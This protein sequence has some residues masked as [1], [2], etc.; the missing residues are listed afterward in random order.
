MPHIVYQQPSYLLHMKPKSFIWD[1]FVVVETKPNGA[2]KTVQCKHDGCQY[3]KAA[4]P[5][6]MLQHWQADHVEPRESPDGPEEDAEE[7]VLDSVDAPLSPPAK[8]Q[9]LLTSYLDRTFSVVEQ[10]HAE[11]SQAFATVMNGQSYN[12]VQQRWT[13]H[14]FHASPTKGL[15]PFEDLQIRGKDQGNRGR[16]P[17]GCSGGYITARVRVHCC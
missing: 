9:C 13:D 12:S 10:E 17:S 2:A 14:R 4:N 6:R 8:K 11:M 7:V 15:R 5:N 3:R 16:H 1:H